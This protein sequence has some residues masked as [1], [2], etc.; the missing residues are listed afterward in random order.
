M[1]KFDVDFVAPFDRSARSMA[2]GIDHHRSPRSTDYADGPTIYRCYKD[3]ISV[4]RWREKKR[5]GR[6]LYPSRKNG[7]LFYC[8]RNEKFLKIMPVYSIK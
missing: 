2:K 4:L 8:N 7:A 3:I 6:N 5:D 1:M